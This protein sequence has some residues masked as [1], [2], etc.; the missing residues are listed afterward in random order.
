[1]RAFSCG[2]TAERAYLPNCIELER[3]IC[4]ILDF[5]KVASGNL[6]L[7]FNIKYVLLAQKCGSLFSIFS[8]LRN[9]SETRA[10]EGRA[11]EERLALLTLSWH[12]PKV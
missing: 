4:R 9:T 8:L 2:S 3:S 5:R 12:A 6:K 7:K 10:A 1:V 11:A